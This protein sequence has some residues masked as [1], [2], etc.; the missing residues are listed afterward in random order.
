MDGVPR[1][2]R[3]ETHKFLSHQSHTTVK[4]LHT[5]FRPSVSFSV[6]FTKK[7]HRPVVLT[8]SQ[9]DA[10]SPTNPAVV[11]GPSPRLSSADLRLALTWI[12]TTVFLSRLVSKLTLLPSFG[13]SRTMGSNSW[14][15]AGNASK[16][17]HQMQRR[18]SCLLIL[19]GR[20]Q[21]HFLNPVVRRTSPS[22]H[23]SVPA[24]RLCCESSTYVSILGRSLD[25][26]SHPKHS[27]SST[28]SW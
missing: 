5:F 14:L 13:L 2:N 3:G 10:A 23:W 7:M 8:S 15:V 6:V 26:P 18:L 17:P 4:P 24:S 16:F 19:L 25:Q 1:E 12:N 9:I 21:Y 11:V 27:W 22:R 20:V 28:K